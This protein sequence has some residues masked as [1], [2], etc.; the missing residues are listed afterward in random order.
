M[1]PSCSF[2]LRVNTVHSLVRTACSVCFQVACCCRAHCIL[3]L[4]CRQTRCTWPKRSVTQ[5]F[6]FSA[7]CFHSTLHHSLVFFLPWPGM[8]LLFCCLLLVVHNY[9][10][11]VL[12]FIT[13]QCFLFFFVKDSYACSNPRQCCLLI[14]HDPLSLLLALVLNFAT[15]RHGSHCRWAGFPLVMQYELF[16]LTRKDSSNTILRG[17]T[18]CGEGLAKCVLNKL[19]LLPWLCCYLSHLDNLPC[20]TWTGGQAVS[21]SHTISST[22]VPKFFFWDPLEEHHQSPEFAVLIGPFWSVGVAVTWH[23]DSR[24]APSPPLLLAQDCLT[25]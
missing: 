17:A 14:L 6:S 1:A 10:M 9:T 5:F 2:F 21:F 16:F 23:E 15:L 18:W 11:L 24:F 12:P 20:G 22:G 8:C 25:K 4:V 13:V 7:T 19:I 3:I